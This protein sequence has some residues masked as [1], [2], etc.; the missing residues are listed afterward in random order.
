M[1]FVEMGIDTPFT[2]M[3]DNVNRK[4]P[5][6]FSSLD[7]FELSTVPF[8]IVPRGSAVR[9]SITTGASTSASNSSPGRALPLDKTVCSRTVRG[10]P[11]SSS[12]VAGTNEVPEDGDA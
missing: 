10:V 9:P 7:A 8:T 3:L 12:S 4:Y 1:L 11:A 6:P 2:T 5:D